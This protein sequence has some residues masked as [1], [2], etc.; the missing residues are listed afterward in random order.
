MCVGGIEVFLCVLGGRRL[1]CL[2]V[3][4]GRVIKLFVC[5]FRG[6]GR[7]NCEYVVF[8]EEGKVKCLYVC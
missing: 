5:V 8:L 1:R 6:R 3:C 7:L 4:F 2:Y